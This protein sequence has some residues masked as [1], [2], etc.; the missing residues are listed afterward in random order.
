MRFDQLNLPIEDNASDKQDSIRLA[1]LMAV[2]DHPEAVPMNRY[3]LIEGDRIPLRDTPDSVFICP[4]NMYVRHPKEYIF[5]L[6]RDQYICAIGGFSEQNKRYL[7]DRKYVNGKDLLSPT[8]TGH[9]LRCK[10]QKASWWHDLW[11]WC[12]M[13][14]HA[15]FTPLSEPNQLLVMLKIAGTD[16]VQ[17]YCKANPKWREA[18]RTYWIA[19]RAKPEVEL[20]EHIIKQIES[21]I[22][23]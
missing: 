20:C 6:S 12:D 8:V 2:F 16:W 1:G 5:D 13:M 19:T 4:K 21:I 9:E 22:A 23:V 11:L 10:G 3:L 18:L 15:K 14:Y 7:I 17:S